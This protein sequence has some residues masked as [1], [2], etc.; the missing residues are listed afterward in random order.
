MM[1]QRS[2]QAYRHAAS[3]AGWA[4]AKLLQRD[5]AVGIGNALDDPGFDTMWGTDM[6][7]PALKSGVYLL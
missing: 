3:T 7:V 4:L 6:Q 1:Q 2:P 5:R